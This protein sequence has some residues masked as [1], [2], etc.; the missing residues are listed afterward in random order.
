[1]GSS[2]SAVD[3]AC[4]WLQMLQLH[5]IFHPTCKSPQLSS[6]FAVQGQMASFGLF[7]L[8][9]RWAGHVQYSYSML[10]VSSNLIEAVAFR[11]GVRKFLSSSWDV[12]LDC[13]PGLV[14]GH[15]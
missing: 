3:C 13:C 8:L 4:R 15:S 12:G 9:L 1:M 5:M 10:P 11:D 14:L 7:P 6:R 2:Q